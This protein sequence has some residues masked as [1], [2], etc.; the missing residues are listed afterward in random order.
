MKTLGIIILV[1]LIGYVLF[2]IFGVILCLTSSPEEQARLRRNLH[3][4]QEARRLKREL[5]RKWYERFTYDPYGGV[6]SRPRP[7]D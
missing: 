6:F 2:L 3:E 7:K 4:K 1:V 5:K